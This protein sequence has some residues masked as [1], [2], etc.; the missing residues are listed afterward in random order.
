MDGELANLEELLH[1]L[2]GG[3]Q[4]AIYKKFVLLFRCSKNNKVE[5]RVVEV[6]GFEPSSD[7]A[8]LHVRGFRS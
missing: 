7:D 3:L 4:I 6:N 2:M 1:L 5:A 8:K